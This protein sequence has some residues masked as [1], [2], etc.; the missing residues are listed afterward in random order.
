MYVKSLN[1]QGWVPEELFVF[2]EEKLYS[3]YKEEINYNIILTG[4][5]WKIAK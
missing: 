3:L 2:L 4:G 1:C 5:H